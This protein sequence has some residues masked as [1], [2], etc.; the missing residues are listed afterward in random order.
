MTSGSTRK[1]SEVGIEIEIA[2]HN[3]DI[4]VTMM[5]DL[6]FRGSILQIYLSTVPRIYLRI[7]GRCRTRERANL[8][9]HISHSSQ[10]MILSRFLT[11]IFRM[12]VATETTLATSTPP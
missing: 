3:S 2:N 8:G 1:F 4:N 7:I 6:R 12:F 11:A 10:C 9:S 5:Q